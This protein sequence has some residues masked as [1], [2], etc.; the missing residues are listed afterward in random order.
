MP[1]IEFLDVQAW[2][3]SLR[4]VCAVEIDSEILSDMHIQ[5][6]SLALGL[7]IHFVS[8][9]ILEFLV[10]TNDCYD[11][12]NLDFYGGFV[13]PTSTG[14]SRC[15][16]AIRC[17]IHRQS[18]RNQS[19]ILVATL[20]VRDR[21]VAEYL[22]FIDNVP[23]ALAGWQNIERCCIVHKKNQATRLKLCFPYLCWH[24]GMSYNFA[25]RFTEAVVYQ[26]TATMIHFYTEFTL[27]ERA[28]PDLTS[29]K[30]LAD[31]ISMP[32]LRLD[33]MIPKVE[34]APPQVDKP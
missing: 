10:S 29:N 2:K 28:L 14:K 33:G 5:W 18:V 17:L 12:Y 3:G 21:G 32:L 25:V 22:A 1:S 19:F 31:M 16:E 9:D 13:N 4:S 20:N 26:S 7:P 24:L 11:L 30:V 15:V 8:A 6:N 27:Q 34:L 23:Q